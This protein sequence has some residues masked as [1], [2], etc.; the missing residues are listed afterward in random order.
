[1]VVTFVFEFLLS[2]G[3][4]KKD[5]TTGKGMQKGVHVCTS[6]LLLIFS[7]TPFKLDQ[8]KKIETVQ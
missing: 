8:N 5:C 4:C 7:V 6:L 1:M 2:N 3:P